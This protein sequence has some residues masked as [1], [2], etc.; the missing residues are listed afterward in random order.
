[1]SSLISRITDVAPKLQAYLVKTAANETPAREI[2]AH[3]DDKCAVSLY[4]ALRTL[5][6]VSILNWEP[7]TIW[8]T[9]DKEGVDLPVE[10]RDRILAAVALQLNPAFY[11]DNLAFQRTVQAF[12]HETFNPE[13]LQENHPAHMAWAVHE[14]A[15]I[16]G[17]DPF[18]QGIPEFDD[19]VQSYVAV[20][21]KRAGYVRAPDELNFCEDTLRKLF[22]KEAEDFRTEVSEAWRDLKKE[23]LQDYEFPET[24]LGVQLARLAGVHEH[25]RIRGKCLAQEIHDLELVRVI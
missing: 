16:R 2:L 4:M 6:G 7:E 12:G 17:L 1:M 15:I 3:S 8:L 18:N 23:G 11:W 14:A 5:Y 19:D 22:H 20:C 10:A 21:L 9:L 24:A 25:L 13:S